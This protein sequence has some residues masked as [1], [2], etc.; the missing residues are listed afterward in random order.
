MWLEGCA[1][2]SHIRSITARKLNYIGTTDSVQTNSCYY[3]PLTM[4][5]SSYLATHHKVLTSKLSVQHQS[6]DTAFS[7]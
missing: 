5:S 4:Y 3:T 6:V 1:A 2:L 7:N